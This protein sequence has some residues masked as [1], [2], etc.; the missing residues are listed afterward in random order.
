M[1]L[2]SV[3]G[4]SLV[5]NVSL[6]SK[7]PAAG[8]SIVWSQPSVIE[9][10][11]ELLPAIARATDCILRRIGDDPRY[12]TDLRPGEINDLI[13]DS[14]RSCARPLRALIDTHDRMYGPGSGEAFL[15]GTFLDVLP[16]AVVR[17]VKARTQSR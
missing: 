8:K 11:A 5:L 16:S 12:S 4:L 3:F 2:E 10:Q 6:E 1:I 17:Q 9:R 7:V 14:L 13:A 15:L